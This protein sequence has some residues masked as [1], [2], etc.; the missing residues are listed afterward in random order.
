MS[1]KTLLWL[2]PMIAGPAPRWEALPSNQQA[3][4]FVKNSG[5]CVAYTFKHFIIC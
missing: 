4:F 3:Y 1:H 2:K 5:F